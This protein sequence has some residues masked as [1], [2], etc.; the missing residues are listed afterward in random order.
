MS[1][2]NWSLGS[3]PYPT[4]NALKLTLGA[5]SLATVFVTPPVITPTSLIEAYAFGFNFDTDAPKIFETFGP[6]TQSSMEFMSAHSTDL[7]P[8]KH[9]GGKMILYQGNSDG[10]F[11]PRDTTRW[12]EAMNEAMGDKARDF[13]R[14][15]LVPGMGH[16]GTGPGTTSFDTL[17]PL[18][19]WVE[20]GVAPDSIVATAPTGTPWPGRTRPLCPY[21]EIAAYTGGGTEAAANFICVPAVE[22]R[23]EPEVLNL[24]SKGAFTA[25]ITLPED[26]NVRDWSISD[27]TCQGVHAVR[28]T[29][30]MHGRTYSAKFETRDLVGVTPGRDVMFTVEGV[31]HHDGKVAPFSGAD[32]VRVIK[33]G[34]DKDCDDR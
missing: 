26:Y 16:C 18:A 29:E 4:N 15:F 13:A 21:P 1:L 22:V 2:R 32:S 31:F 19:N 24:H 30:C 33:E 28:Q 5:G 25:F 3:G 8:F 7:W 11:S 23:I 9:H 20:H 34:K 17:T 27:V 10:S 6:Y 12:Y 14:L